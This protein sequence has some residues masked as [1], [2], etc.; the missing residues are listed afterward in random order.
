MELATEF[1]GRLERVQAEMDRQGLNYLLVGPS[2]DLVYL[3]GYDVKLS[4]RL[5]LLVLPRAGRPQLVMP[6]FEVPGTT[7]LPRTFDTCA[8]SDGTDAHS[9]ALSIL[10]DAGASRRIGVGPQLQARFVLDLVAAGLD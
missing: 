4:E 3:I 1:G 6:D 8:W 9:F 2:S 10:G 5:T 7:A